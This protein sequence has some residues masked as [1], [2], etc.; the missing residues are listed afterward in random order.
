M[1]ASSLRHHFLLMLKQKQCS[2][3][4][5]AATSYNCTAHN[6][7]W[8]TANYWHEGQPCGQFC[9]MHGPTRAQTLCGM[10][11]RE[12]G[13]ET[14]SHPHCESQER[15]NSSGASLALGLFFKGDN[16]GR[17]LSS[18]DL[19]ELSLYLTCMKGDALKRGLLRRFEDDSGLW[20]L[21]LVLLCEKEKASLPGPGKNDAA[22]NS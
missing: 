2:P 13:S 5:C 11:Q 10:F 9:K 19:P 22:C 18:E 8:F 6:P 7:T 3:T 12:R 14:A 21:C 17:R 1:I 15:A 16:L 20:D 4:G